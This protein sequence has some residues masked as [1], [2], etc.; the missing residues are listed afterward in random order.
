M[1]TNWENS[2]GIASN[3]W[4][5]RCFAVAAEEGNLHRAAER[6]CLSQPPLSRH[7]KRLEDHLGVA[8]FVRHAKGL[9][10]TDEGRSVLEIIRP[11]LEMQEETD[12]KLDTLVQSAARKIVVGFTTALEQGVFS[13]MEA[14]LTAAY[15]SRLRIVRAPSPKLALNVRKGKLDAAL[16]ALPL[17]S[18]GVNITLTGYAEPLLAGVPAFWPEAKNVA[19]PL[20]AFTGRPLFWFRRD[21]NPAFFDFTKGVFAHARFFPHYLEEPAEHDVLLARIA[22]GEGMS[23]L[24]SSFAAIQRA[25]VSFVSLVEVPALQLQLG[26][27]ARRETDENVLRLLKTVSFKR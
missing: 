22:A 5:W 12:R 27:V 19:L 7:I 11:L 24:P 18:S 8:L 4:V 13:S 26:I 9:T 21:M 2:S 17:E 10:L 25:G 6:L 14:Q 16:V 1:G 15:A 23:L 20:Y 3:L